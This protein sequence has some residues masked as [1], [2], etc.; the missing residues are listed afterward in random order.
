MQEKIKNKGYWDTL[1]I[2]LLSDNISE[3]GSQE[4]ALWISASTKHQQYFNQMKELWNSTAVAD[5]NLPFDYEKAY[6]LFRR[7]V[8]EKTKFALQKRAK[9]IVWRRISIVAAVMIPFVLLSYYS[10]F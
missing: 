2:D 1:I 3:E 8:D 10:L 6:A 5:P 9:I 7:R 4:L